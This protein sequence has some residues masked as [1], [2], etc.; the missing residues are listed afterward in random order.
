MKDAAETKQRLSHIIH[1]TGFV[2]YGRE[3]HKPSSLGSRG[4]SSP[5]STA[6]GGHVHPQESFLS[7]S[8]FG[9]FAQL[10]KRVTNRVTLHKINGEGALEE[11]A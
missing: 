2:G 8:I 3:E 10:L 11:S 1:S 5:T 7:Q 6:T 9:I 4:G